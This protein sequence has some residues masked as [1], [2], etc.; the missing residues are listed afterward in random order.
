VILE[1]EA[2]HEPPGLGI[3]LGVELTVG[4]RPRVCEDLQVL[5]TDHQTDACN[6][7]IAGGFATVFECRRWSATDERPTSV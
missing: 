4:C 7:N 6:A 2:P 5:R 3:E 1:A